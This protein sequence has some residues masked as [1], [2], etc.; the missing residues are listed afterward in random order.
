MRVLCL[1]NQN[2]SA[3]DKLHLYACQT[4]TNL[5]K[6]LKQASADAQLCTYTR[7]ISLISTCDKGIDNNEDNKA[8]SSDNNK[9]DSSNSESS[10]EDDSDGEDKGQR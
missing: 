1:A 4:D 9:E 5:L 6:Y 8:L 2:N 7:I 3:M 10:V